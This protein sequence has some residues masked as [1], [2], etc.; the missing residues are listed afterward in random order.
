MNSTVHMNEWITHVAQRSFNR[1]LGQQNSVEGQ[2]GFCPPIKRHEKIV[3]TLIN[4]KSEKGSPHIS[5]HIPW[6]LRLTWPKGTWERWGFTL[7]SEINFDQCRKMDEF[8]ALIHRAWDWTSAPSSSVKVNFEANRLLVP[9]SLDWYLP[10]RIKKKSKDIN[11]N[12]LVRDGLDWLPYRQQRFEF[13]PWFMRFVRNR[14][15]GS[16]EVIV[17]PH[18]STRGFRF[19]SHCVESVRIIHLPLTNSCQKMPR[20]T[21]THSRFKR[22]RKARAMFMKF[23]FGPTSV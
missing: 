14:Q 7:K 23:E 12:H 6:T 9:V 18:W 10:Y 4:S 8:V 15:W 11:H 21:W 19:D 16:L 1:P 2:R 13:P 22:E 3:K 5:E 17:V 20:H